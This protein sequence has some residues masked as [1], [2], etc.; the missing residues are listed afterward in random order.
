[1]DACGI[2]RD[3]TSVAGSGTWAYSI[4]NGSTFQT[5]SG[6]NPSAALLLPQNTEL[7]YTPDGL[8]T[9]PATITYYAWDPTISGVARQQGQPVFDRRRGRRYGL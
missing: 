8:Q 7:R 2:G 1:V 9:G 3:G 6:V 4:N 5:I